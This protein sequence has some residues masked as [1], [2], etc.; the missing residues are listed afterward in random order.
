VLIRYFAYG[1]NLLSARLRERT[2]SAS[3]VGP[4]RLDAH[5]LR[6]HKAGKDGSGKCDIVEVADPSKYVL[7]VVYELLE[8]EKP[9]L[10]LAESLGVGYAQKTV[11]V[12]AG[13]RRTEA[14]AY[15]ALQVDPA[16]VPY[17]WYKNLVVAGAREH[18]LEPAYQAALLA[19][20]SKPDPDQE[21]AMRHFRL[22][23]AR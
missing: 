2:P 23:G 20:A 8:S 22:A 7:G 6:W 4:A 15:F 12:E 16:A 9:A 3:A 17:D 19:A 21:R 5:E 10:D 13:G 14:L 11:L 18:G 1:S